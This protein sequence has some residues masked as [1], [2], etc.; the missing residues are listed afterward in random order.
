MHKYP[1]KN[2]NGDSLPRNSEGFFASICNAVSFCS[3]LAVANWGLYLSNNS[4][5]TSVKCTSQI[6]I[7]VVANI[8]IRKWGLPEN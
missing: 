8:V 6:A 4:M 2:P 5:A 3:S 7:Y 1:N